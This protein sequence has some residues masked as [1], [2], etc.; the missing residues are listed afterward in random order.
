MGGKD[1]IHWICLFHQRLPANCLG[2]M[3]YH[4]GIYDRQ[5]VL[6]LGLIVY[7]LSVQRQIFSRLFNLN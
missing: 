4:K 2:N 6:D 7:Y 5:E 1:I 3:E